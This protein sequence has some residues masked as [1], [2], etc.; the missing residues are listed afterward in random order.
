MPLTPILV[1][2]QLSVCM[3]VYIYIFV[4]V[5]VCAYVYLYYPLIPAVNST[6]HEAKNLI[7]LMGVYLTPGL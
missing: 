1:K 2:G 6:F 7:L 5:C 4:Y 3:C